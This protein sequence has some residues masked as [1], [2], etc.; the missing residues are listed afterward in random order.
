[1][2]IMRRRLTLLVAAVFAVLIALPA[3]DAT[4]ED[5]PARPVTLIVPFPPGGS[6]TIMARIVAERMSASLGQQVIVDN[7]GGAG[8]TIGTRA[9]AKSAPDG[10]T[11]VLGY[12]GTLAIAPS[13]YTNPGYDPRKDFAPIG[14]IGTAPSVLVVH[15]SVPAKSVSELIKYIKDKGELHFGSPGAGTLNHLAA[16]LFAQLAG[17]KLT[18]IPYKG[19]GPAMNDLLGG[20]I[21]MMFVPIPVAHG[22][23]AAG[24]LRAL[25]V[26]TSKR[27]P[28]L[29]DLPTMAESGVPGF[30]VSLR[31]GLAAPAGTP[32]EIVD[33]LNKELNAALASDEVKRRLATEG[34]DPIS[35]TPKDYAADIDREEKMWSA[36]VKR[37]GIKAE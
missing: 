2:N 16:E 18:H 4:A 32:P 1:M 24:T 30:D 17:V 28:L 6:T 7:R 8:G 12:T 9:A 27:S 25:A 14:M 13:L 31:Y 33:R 37:I 3:P 10:Y 35:G 21:P 20:H 11:M 15:P 36:L 22:N 19:S 29:A 26:S 34:A 5:Y 23:I